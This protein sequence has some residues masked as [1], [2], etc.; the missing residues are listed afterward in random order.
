MCGRLARCRCSYLH[1]RRIDR[2]AREAADVLLS[3][4]AG[5]AARL[6]QADQEATVALAEP[7]VHRGVTINP[8][9]STST[10][11]CPF[12][13]SR[14]RLFRGD[15]TPR[16][17]LPLGSAGKAGP[18]SRLGRQGPGLGLPGPATF[19][20]RAQMPYHQPRGQRRNGSGW[21]SSWA[22]HWQGVG[23]PRGGITRN[24]S[25]PE[26]ANYPD[27]LEVG[28]IAEDGQPPDDPSHLRDWL[29]VRNIRRRLV[30][31]T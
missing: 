2:H 10:F 25:R 14:V 30:E 20:G 17:G 4:L 6:N 7:C 13:L 29:M 16:G 21:R 3:R 31:A 5:D 12:G 11:L 9:S 15:P 26:R 27:V 8:S 22:G 19:S 23:P 24:P 28:S 1:W 18:D